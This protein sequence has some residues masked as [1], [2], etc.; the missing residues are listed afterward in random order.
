MPRVDAPRVEAPRVGIGR[1]RSSESEI[2]RQLPSNT[3]DEVKTRSQNKQEELLSDSLTQTQL[4]DA[5]QSYLH[6]HSDLATPLRS[7]F[8]HAED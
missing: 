1:G 3:T 4:T 6:Q 5:M 2:S 7:R 8:S